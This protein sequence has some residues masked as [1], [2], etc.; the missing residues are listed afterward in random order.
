MSDFSDEY[1]EQV[2]KADVAPKLTC[3]GCDGFYRGPVRY[4]LNNH[5]VCSSCLPEDKNKCP[6][7]GCDK[8]ALI[9]LDWVSDLVKDLRFPVPCK[10]RKDGCVQEDN[11]EEV[12]TEHEIECGY[13]KVKCLWSNCPPQRVVDLE[14]HIFSAH[15]AH[16]EYCRENPGKWLLINFAGGDIK[17]AHKMWVDSESGLRFWALLYHNDKG[18]HWVCYTIA[19]AGE[20]V[21][22]KYRVEMR[23]SSYDEDTSLV[24]NCN[25]TS[26]DEVGQ[27]PRSKKFYIN[28]DQFKIYNKGLAELGDH[29]KDKNGEL[30]MPVTIEINKKKLNCG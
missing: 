7:E 15:P 19:F 20:R 29:N 14:A 10:F 22:N 21:A 27:I 5:G 17:G 30:T 18:K 8:D 28:D 25:V 9:S 16:C 4:C 6:V 12:I 11:I 2:R 26:L 1:I 3:I 24:Y 13:R 23:I